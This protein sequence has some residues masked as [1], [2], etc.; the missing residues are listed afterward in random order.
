MKKVSNV[1]KEVATLLKP[2]ND[3][4]KQHIARLAKRSDEEMKRYVSVL[5]EDFQ[6]KVQVIGEQFSGLNN[7]IDIINDT[8]DSHTEMIGKLAE[9]MTI[10]KVNVEFLKG[11]LKKK[12]DY[13]EFLALER[14]LSLLESKVK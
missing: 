7:K 1:S 8:L 6:T 12:V 5:T 3:E 4:I 13:D 9:D 11:G 14:R 2:Y 10:V